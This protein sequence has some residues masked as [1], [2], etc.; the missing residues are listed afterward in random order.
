MKLLISTGKQNE[1]LQKTLKDC[2]SRDGV[3]ICKCMT[4]GDCLKVE[5][6]KRGLVCTKVN[7]FETTNDGVPTFFAM[8]G[9][10][11]RIVSNCYTLIIVL[12]QERWSLLL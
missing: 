2:L 6:S 3:D 7:L 10:K 12:G 4:V 9:P 8:F 5:C 1:L 11:N